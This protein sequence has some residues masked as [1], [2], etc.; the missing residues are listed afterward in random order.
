MAGEDCKG[1]T[2]RSGLEKRRKVDALL[3]RLA[4]KLDAQGTSRSSGW[5]IIERLKTLEELKVLG[6][7]IDD[8][9]A[10]YTAKVESSTRKGLMLGDYVVV[11]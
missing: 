4:G 6:R 1:L 3:E 9:D 8:S 2:D 11:L 7:V 10:I 5:L